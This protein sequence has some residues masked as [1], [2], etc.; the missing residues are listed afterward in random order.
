MAV[1][2]DV[3]YM[4]PDFSAQYLHNL[5]LEVTGYIAAEKY[6]VPVSDISSEQKESIYSLNPRFFD[7]KSL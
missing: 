4:G 7:Q 1:S 3:D 5:A 6:K 2:G